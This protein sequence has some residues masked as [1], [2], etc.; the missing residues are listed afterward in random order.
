MELIN[1][2]G[3]LSFDSPI[4]TSDFARLLSPNAWCLVSCRV[5]LMRV[6]LAHNRKRAVLLFQA[7]DAES[8]RQAFRHT[9]AHFDQIWPCASTR[10]Q[11]PID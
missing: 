2:I 1:V 9:E 5:R 4:A 8:V 3:E 7:P 10:T 6:F 11:D